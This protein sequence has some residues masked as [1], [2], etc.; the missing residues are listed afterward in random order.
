MTKMTKIS[1]QISFSKDT[2]LLIQ[3][4]LSR[5]N[6]ILENLAAVDVVLFPPY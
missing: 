6:E 2:S 5:K 3:F 4:L 1:N